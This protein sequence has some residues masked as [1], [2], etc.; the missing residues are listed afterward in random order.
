M[1]TVDLPCLAICVETK[2]CKYPSALSYIN[3][4][5]FR[6]TTQTPY[7]IRATQN[8]LGFKPIY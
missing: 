5:I 2:Y 3:K 8:N 7:K 6:K 1:T 4:I